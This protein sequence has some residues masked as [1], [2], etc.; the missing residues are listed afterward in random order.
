[1]IDLIRKFKLGKITP[2]SCGFFRRAEARHGYDSPSAA[3]HDH[4][5]VIFTHHA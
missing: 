4:A 2:G 5:C 3:S 1:M